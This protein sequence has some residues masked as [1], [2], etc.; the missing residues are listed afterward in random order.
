MKFKL[1]TSTGGVGK[2]HPIDDL[3]CVVDWPR[4]V[5]SLLLLLLLLCSTCRPTRPN[6][7]III[8]YCTF[9]TCNVEISSSCRWPFGRSFGRL[10][11]LTCRWLYGDNFPLLGEEFLFN[12]QEIHFKLCNCGCSTDQASERK[13]WTRAGTGMLARSCRQE[14]RNFVSPHTDFNTVPI[15][16]LAS[17]PDVA[18][19]SLTR[20]RYSILLT[21][22]RCF[23]QFFL[24]EPLYAILESVHIYIPALVAIVCIVVIFYFGLASSSS[25]S[26][27]PQEYLQEMRSGRAEKT[28]VK[29]PSKST[30]SKLNKSSKSTKQSSSNKASS[31]TSNMQKAKGDVPTA[32][33]SGHAKSKASRAR[34]MREE[35]AN[36]DDVEMNE[37]LTN[38]WVTVTPRRGKQQNDIDSAK[39]NKKGQKKKDKRNNSKIRDEDEVSNDRIAGSQ[40]V[41]RPAV[42]EQKHGK[43]LNSNVA[44]ELSLH[45][46]EEIPSVKPEKKNSKKSNKAKR[47]GKLMFSRRRWWL[48]S[49]QMPLWSRKFQIQNSKFQIRR[50]V[51]SPDGSS[52]SFALAFDCL[53]SA[54]PR[55]Q[56]ASRFVLKLIPSKSFRQLKLMSEE[57]KAQQATADGPTIFD[58]I[59]DKSI[60]AS[61]IYEDSEVMAF[62]DI[63]P[64]APVHFLVIPKKRLNQL[65]DATEEHQAMLGKLLLTAKKCANMML[66]ENGYR[67]VINNGREGCQSVYHLHLHVLGGRMMKW[68]PG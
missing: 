67:V 40:A 47:Q 35:R 54:E 45:S 65:S 3:C 49:L 57:K 6:Y 34:E 21:T 68:P 56:F 37:D 23:L 5:L 41:K 58:K 63:N 24:M 44:A 51:A 52:D 31:T 1:I 15:S 9:V 46:E 48:M 33:G 53:C 64:Q 32:A 7:L 29:S 66:L 61:I 36:S 13:R 11:C 26:Q 28:K 25:T 2:L 8:N 62:H 55:F 10:E 14:K 30:N 19:V 27:P 17:S 16:A 22:G 60:P 42:K 4:L 12:F 38:G 20:R 39:K 50:N 18:H 43:L 59:I